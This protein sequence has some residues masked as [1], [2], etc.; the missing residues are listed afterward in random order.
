MEVFYSKQPVITAVGIFSQNVQDTLIITEIM[1][2]II[3][4]PG[5]PGGVEIL[6]LFLSWIIIAGF[7]GRWVYRD[8][9]RRG[10]N[11]A[12]QWG[13]GIAV[14][15]VAGGAGILALIIYVVIRGEKV[16]NDK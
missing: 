10:S 12:W 2:T 8:A 9:K 7:A 1:F 13:V 4:L 11:W 6:V 3:Q 5:L 14:L 15:L 16:K